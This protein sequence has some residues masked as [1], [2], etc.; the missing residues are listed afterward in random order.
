MVVLVVCSGT[1]PGFSFMKHQAFIYDQMEAINKLESGI[2]FQTFFIKQKG[3]KGYMS[4]LKALK[5]EIK[6]FKPV[7]VH[8]HG[9]TVALLCNLQ[10]HVPV[11]ATFHGSDIHYMRIRW[12]SAI[13]GLLSRKSIYVSQQLRRKAILKKK[14][15]VVIPCGIDLVTFHPLPQEE[16]RKTLG[17]PENEPFILFCSQ[18]DNPV[19]NFTL[20]REAL[21]LLPSMRVEE[22]AHRTRDEVNL[23]ING[24]SLVLLT[25]FSEGS[26]NVIKEAMACNCPVVSVDV[27]DVKEVIRNTDGCYITSYEPPD[28][29]EKIK[30]ALAF[31]RRTKGRER[32]RHLESS[33]IARRVIETYN[34]IVTPSE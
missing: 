29:A 16:A 30:M 15:D 21:K 17:F 3:L 10:R 12:L 22:I 34:S 23:L 11:I 2:F 9:G 8:A 18:F 24:A 27:G 19:K 14:T 25:S 6:Q 31:G 20:A 5:R 7:L 32:I 13:A 4:S 28:I 33:I 1:A 26:P